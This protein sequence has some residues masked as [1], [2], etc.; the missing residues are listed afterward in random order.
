MIMNYRLLVAGRP[1]N[2]KGSNY[3]QTILRPEFFFVLPTVPM[4]E[5]VNVV[6]CFG[7]CA[8]ARGGVSSASGDS[9]NPPVAY[10]TGRCGAV[11]LALFFNLLGGGRSVLHF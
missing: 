1:L 11:L 8:R 2:V 7:G 10:S 3:F 9:L 4:C 6:F 5:S